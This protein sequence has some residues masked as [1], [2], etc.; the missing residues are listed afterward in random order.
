MRVDRILAVALVTPLLVT[1]FLYGAMLQPM[2]FGPP[3]ASRMCYEG[4]P[5]QVR[6]QLYDSNLPV[7]FAHVRLYSLDGRLVASADT[8]PGGECS[9]IKGVEPGRY[10]AVVE[11]ARHIFIDVVDV[12]DVAGGVWKRQFFVGDDRYLTVVNYGL[13]DG[14]VEAGGL[15]LDVPPLTAVHVPADWNTASRR[16]GSASGRSWSR[17][18]E[19]SGTR[20]TRL[21]RSSSTWSRPCS[22]RRCPRLRSA[23]GG[24]TR[25]WR[26]P[27]S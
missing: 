4:P 22:S 17:S 3:D 23:A 25:R 7:P 9:P 16:A 20:G 6:I 2:R 27:C 11:G 1:L 21:R 10:L 26:S 24:G 19:C 15:A 18:P 14:R 12:Y 13:L 8:G 5:I